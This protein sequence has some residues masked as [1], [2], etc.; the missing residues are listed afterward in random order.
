[1]DEKADMRTVVLSRR[2]Q[3]SSDIRA[4]KSLLICQQLEQLAAES[5]V[6]APLVAVYAAM[7]SEVDL[8]AF[9]N[10]A[11]ARGWSVCFPCIVRNA[12]DSPSR[13]A[14]YPVEPGRLD[15]AHQAFLGR[16]L[17]CLPCEELA[18]AGYAEV[19][20]HAIDVM[21]VPLVAFD[22]DGC[23]L[24]YGGGN[25]DQ[26]LPLLREDALVAGIAFEEQ[27]VISVPVEPHDQPL[28][29]VLSA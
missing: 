20:P 12:Q 3:L 19:A 7:R 18:A 28:P 26:F 22:D 17:R 1:M 23:R 29:R 14:F 25:Y 11:H 9:V 16:P 5:P 27:R 2:D 4:Q 21:A 10:A 15:H 6:C 13:M 24:G 8:G